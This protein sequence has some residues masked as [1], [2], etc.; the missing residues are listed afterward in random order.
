MK[1]F[2]PST[3]WTPFK[4]APRLRYIPTREKEVRSTSLFVNIKF[5]WE[6]NFLL[7]WNFRAI[8]AVFVTLWSISQ[9]LWTSG[10]IA[11]LLISINFQMYFLP[12]GTP[13]SLFFSSFARIFFIKTKHSPALT[14]K[15][16]C[17]EDRWPRSLGGQ[18]AGWIFRFPLLVWHI[19]S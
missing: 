17:V 6:K 11:N 5:F 4:C 16:S 2:E 12:D 10:H 3:P 8:S 18:D 15:I 13:R 14:K 7:L 9:P 19:I 1:G